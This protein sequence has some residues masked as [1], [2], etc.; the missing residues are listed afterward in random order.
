MPDQ[1]GHA[2]QSPGSE[3]EVSDEGV[4]QIID[5]LEHG[6]VHDDPEFV[7]RLNKLSS[8]DVANAV[9]VILLLV[10]SALLLG[11]GLAA[12]SG[13]VWVAGAAA[14]VMSFGVDEHYKR[15]VGA[16]R[17]EENGSMVHGRA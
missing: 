12:R 17:P 6:L 14:F 15:R 11:L 3:V 13:L 5:A 9:Q 16:R 1:P 2:A 10:V 8:A 4:D 7:R